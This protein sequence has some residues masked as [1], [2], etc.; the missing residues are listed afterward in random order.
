[1]ANELRTRFDDILDL[2]E[3]ARLPQ[4]ILKPGR[5]GSSWEIEI[6]GI[7]R[8]I[9]KDVGACMSNAH[10]WLEGYREGVAA[11]KQFRVQGTQ[12][13]RFGPS[14]EELAS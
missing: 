14:N 12:T 10:L 11:I 6:P 3:E 2:C 1:M 13:G 7:R 9:S 5:L 4:P 8:F